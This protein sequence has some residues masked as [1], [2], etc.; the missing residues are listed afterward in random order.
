M[1]HRQQQQPQQQPNFGDSGRFDLANFSSNGVNLLGNTAPGVNQ[2][3]GGTMMS[4]MGS[5]PGGM[6]GLH[7]RTPSG[8]TMP[9]GGGMGNVS[10]EVLQ[11]FM[12]R[13][14]DGSGGPSQ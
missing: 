10:Y 3:I 2:T 5:Q 11:S 9:Q 7:R 8:N 4:L 6:G 14:A 12:Q 13:N 1:R